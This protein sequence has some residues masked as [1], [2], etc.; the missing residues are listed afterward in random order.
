MRYPGASVCSECRKSLY[1]L[2]SSVLM[3]HAVIHRESGL[4]L[5]SLR[6]RWFFA[7]G[8]LLVV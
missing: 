2:R 3:I 6:V 4:E 5:S 8:S 1:K 7:D